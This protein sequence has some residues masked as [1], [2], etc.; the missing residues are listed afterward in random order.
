MDR[1]PLM[2]RKV[3][4]LLAVVGIVAASA[5]WWGR[6]WA[7]VDACLDAGGRWHSR[8]G[9][10][11]TH[12]GIDPLAIAEEHVRANLQKGSSIS[13][14]EREWFVQDHG[15]IWIVEMSAQGSVGGGTKMAIGKKDGRVL[16]SERTQ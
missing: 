6:G 10:C 12:S 15:D 7:A 3:V 5:A 9:Y 1:K 11:Q 14:L 8:G 2:E 16:G 4:G 13:P